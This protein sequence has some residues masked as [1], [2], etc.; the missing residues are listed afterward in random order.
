MEGVNPIRPL[1][2]TRDTLYLFFLPLLFLS[3]SLCI[4]P[5]FSPLTVA[6]GSYISQLD[7][8]SLSAQMQSS[9]RE[10][11][12]YF[13]FS[14]PQPVQLGRIN[15]I[16]LR[17]FYLHLHAL[18]YHG[19]RIRCFFCLNVGQRKKTDSEGMATGGKRP[20]ILSSFQLTDL[21]SKIP[22]PF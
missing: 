17:C 5:F 19:R 18:F 4:S 14:P 8:F 1:L 2:Q 9:R 3:L 20:S 6:T 21:Y 15:I 11:I 12:K 22:K 10:H 13:I 16:I 7:I